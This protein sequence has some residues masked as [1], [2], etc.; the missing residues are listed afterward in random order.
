MNFRL[1]NSTA[2]QIILV[3]YY[4]LLN[5]TTH[6]YLCDKFHTIQNSLV[7]F[8]MASSTFS[9]ML[10]SPYHP[11]HIFGDEDTWYDA[12]ADLPQQEIEEYFD[13]LEDQNVLIR[14]AVSNLIHLILPL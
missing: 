1:S 4:N 13:A 11:D 2:G 8:T 9:D 10:Q 14:W 7:I 12:P 5:S 6:D 3:P